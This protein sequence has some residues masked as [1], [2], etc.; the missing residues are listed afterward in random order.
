MA[1][2]Y[3]VHKWFV[4]RVQI[5]QC[6]VDLRAKAG[7]PV[8]RE[9]VACIADEALRLERAG[10]LRADKEELDVLELTG[11][12]AWTDVLFV[13]F[14]PEFDA[15]HDP[16]VGWMGARPVSDPAACM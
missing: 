3:L 8:L 13:Y 16:G 2:A 1:R 5:C 12:G 4:R 9:T 14:N 6:Q 10:L 7:N 15:V 11:P